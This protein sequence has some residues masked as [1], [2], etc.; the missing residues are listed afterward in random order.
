MLDPVNALH[1]AVSLVIL[2]NDAGRMQVVMQEDH[3]GPCADKFVLPNVVVCEDQTLEEAARDLAEAYGLGDVALDQSAMFSHLAID[4][5][6]RVMTSGFLG[7]VPR[8]RLG[9]MAASNNLALIDITMAGDDALLSLSGMPISIGH[10][11]DGVVSIAINKLR[12][13][14]DHSLKPFAFVGETFTWAELQSA[15]EAILGEK[16]I[17]QWFRKKHAKRVFPGDR[18]ITGIGAFSR[19]AEG[20][21]AELFTLARVDLASRKREQNVKKWRAKMEKAF[22]KREKAQGIPLGG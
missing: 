11:H 16:I 7:A 15:H 8:S 12:E 13:A 2:A 6:G 19:D 1:V 4:P 17:P 5:R 9:F 20:R 10:L 14:V 18:M 22:A 3:D 21:P